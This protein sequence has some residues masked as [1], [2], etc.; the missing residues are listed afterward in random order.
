E[1]KG[2]AS[3]PVTLPV[4]ATSPGIFTA[5]ASGS[6]QGAI[7]LEDYSLNTAQ[8]AVP[9]GRP[10]MVFTTLGGENGVDGMLAG[11][12]AQHP[13]PVTATIGGKDAQVIY[14]GPSPG[15]I[16]G[17]TQVNVIVPDSAP[18]GLAV[19][20]VITVGGRSTQSGVTMAIK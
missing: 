19:P 10:A 12:I 20:I 13:L 1:Y 16:W 8:N 2:R 15:L 6:G 18:T 17:L 9:R 11:G 5:A 4:A 3:A 7:L 14:A